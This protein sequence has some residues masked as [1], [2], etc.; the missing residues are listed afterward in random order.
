MA[1]IAATSYFFLI[2][3]CPE[4]CDDGNPCT[5][6]FCSAETNHQCKHSPIEGAIEGC[7]D[8]VET[9]KQ[10]QCIEEKCQIVT[11]PVLLLR[12]AE[13]KSG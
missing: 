1:G 10:Y 13:E 3:R 4:S 7:K 11:L 5:Q 9:C 6:D 2:P 8:L 12:P